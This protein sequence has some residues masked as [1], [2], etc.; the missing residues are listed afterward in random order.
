MCLTW[1]L[2]FI[3]MPSCFCIIYIKLLISNLKWW[4]VDLEYLL[5]GCYTVV[6]SCVAIGET[7]FWMICAMPAYFKVFLE[8]SICFSLNSKVFCVWFSNFS[9]AVCVYIYLEHFPSVRCPRPFTYALSCYLL[10]WP[11]VVTWCFWNVLNYLT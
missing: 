1:L 6:L 10:V 3:L 11:V 4:Y 9:F 8:L 7:N 2:I 5:Y